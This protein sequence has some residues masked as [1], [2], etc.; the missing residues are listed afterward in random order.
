MSFVVYIFHILG[1]CHKNNNIW[2]PRSR[3]KH[4]TQEQQ[5]QQQQQQ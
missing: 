4:E 3:E 5:Q 2:F 1:I